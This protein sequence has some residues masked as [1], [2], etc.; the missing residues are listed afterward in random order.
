MAGGPA[1]KE[2]LEGGENAWRWVVGVPNP[3][4]LPLPQAS[5]AG[6]LSRRWREVTAWSSWS[7]LSL[8]EQL[9]L[10]VGVGVCV[11]VGGGMGG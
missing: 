7:M 8:V 3:L 11:C 2:T 5:G 1:A 9:Q 6:N 4:A 10:G